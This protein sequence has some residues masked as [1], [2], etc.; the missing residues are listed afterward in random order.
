MSF[1]H[2]LAIL[3]FIKFPS[4]GCV[5][6]GEHKNLAEGEANEIKGLEG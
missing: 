2:L 1:R 3:S 5:M 4:L 6:R